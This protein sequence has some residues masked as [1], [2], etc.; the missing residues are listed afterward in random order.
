MGFYRK[1]GNDANNRG[2]G[3]QD[4]LHTKINMRYTPKN[5]DK[6]FL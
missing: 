2:K 5:L 1:P 6:F 3:G 4:A